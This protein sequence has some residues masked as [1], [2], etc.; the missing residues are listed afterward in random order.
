M[1]ITV[2]KTEVPKQ[3]PADE[4]ALGF[5][6]IF[7]DHMFMMEYEKGK[8]WLDPRVEPYKKIAL[9]PASMVLHYGQEIFEGLKAYHAAN[10]DILLFRPR[11]NAKRL[12]QSAER[13]C[14]PGVDE[15]FFIEALRTLV[16]LERDWVPKSLGSSLYLRPTMIAS[17]VKLGVHTS[18]SYLFYIICAPSG[19]YYPRGLAPIR[20]YVEDK[21][22]RSVKGGTGYAKTGGNYAS[23]LKGATEAAAKGY[24]QV[25]WLDGLERKYVEEVGA[26]NIM[27]LLD[28]KLCTPAW[29]GSILPGI[30]RN[31]VITLAKDMG[32]PVE[33]RNISIDELMEG[34][35]NGKLQ[36]V[37]G[38]GTAAVVSPVGELTYKGESVTINKNEIGGISQKMYDTLLG[39]QC[40]AI[41]DNHGWVVKV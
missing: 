23:S 1:K 34:G 25:L 15:D 39:I 12:N 35:K 2:N 22:V 13:M 17:D 21:Y 28:G 41:L 37:F 40:G 31:S 26:M 18:H 33:E 32:I 8:G 3:K 20:I 16:N 7:S 10:G 14:M 6:R 29:E 36:E 19:A 38:A 11:D 24:D 5:G 27:F 4:S 30:T 9:D